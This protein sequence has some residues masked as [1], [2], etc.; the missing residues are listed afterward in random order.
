MFES[1]IHKELGPLAKFA[2]FMPTDGPPI[3][4]RM[5]GGERRNV[6]SSNGEGGYGNAC[7]DVKV[8]GKVLRLNCTNGPCG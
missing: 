5:Q 8:V 7:G 6:G 4:I 3:V 2:N 1:T